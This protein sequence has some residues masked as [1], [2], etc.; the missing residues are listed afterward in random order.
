VEYHEVE[1]GV[2]QLPLRSPE[3]CWCDRRTSKRNCGNCCS[4]TAPNFASW[5]GRYLTIALR[6]AAAAN[7]P[8]QP[9]KKR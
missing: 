3:T 1:H 4:K 2:S 9:L 5:D 8:S 6:R 7:P